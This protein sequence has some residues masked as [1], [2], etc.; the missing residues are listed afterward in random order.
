M[1]VFVGAVV[2]AVLV[3]ACGTLPPPHTPDAAPLMSGS[4]ARVTSGGGQPV[5]IR[6][7]NCRR[8]YS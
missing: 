3:S 7:W 5:T 2:L 4:G 8:C 6:D 1:K